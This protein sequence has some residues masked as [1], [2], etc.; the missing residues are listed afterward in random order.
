MVKMK[1]ISGN[2]YA[3]PEYPRNSYNRPKNTKRIFSEFLRQKY[4]TSQLTVLI[5]L[6]SLLQKI[7]VRINE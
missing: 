5:S 3:T 4:F 1:K 6:Q 7:K 2:H